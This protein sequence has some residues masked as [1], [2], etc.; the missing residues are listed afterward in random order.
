M[1]TTRSVGNKEEADLVVLVGTDGTALVALGGMAV[2][3]NVA[4][5]VA[6]S[7][8]PIKIGGIAEATSPSGVSDG[9]RVNAWFDLL[10]RQVVAGAYSKTAVLVADGQVKGSAGVLHTV[11]ISCND[12][13]PTAGSLIIYDSLTE[14][15]TQVFNHTFVTSP[16]APLTLVF[17]AIM[18]T[19][20]YVGFTT[21]NDINVT[22]TYL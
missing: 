16:I 21:T 7:G 22:V 9:Q 11:V 14:T 8:G 20:I 3:G 13:A 2:N 10:G 1:A 6:D 12:A 5:G 15:G 17:D 18:T 19:G 4:S